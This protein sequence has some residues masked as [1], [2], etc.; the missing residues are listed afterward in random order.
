[1]KRGAFLTGEKNR[2]KTHEQLW[3]LEDGE[4]STPVHDELVLQL[5]NPRN[6]LNMCN[7]IGYNEDYW[8][9]SVTKVY[10][11]YYALDNPSSYYPR[12]Y[13]YSDDIRTEFDEFLSNSHASISQIGKQMYE[14]FCERE[15]NPIIDISC[16]YP[17][18]TGHN[19]FIIGYLDIKYN[20]T[21]LKR[22]FDIISN[23]SYEYLD[24]WYKDYEKII[25]VC[26]RGTLSV[27]NTSFNDT[28]EDVTVNIE[29]KP[30][31][32]SF[33][34]TLRQINTYRTCFSG[35]YVIYSPDVRFKAAFESQ[36]VRFI[37]PSDLGIK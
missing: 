34:E 27:I 12:N 31:I 5:M 15:R 6:A 10:P 14:N 30:K 19:K 11:N 33:G 25:K 1:L 16:E 4:L 24:Q 26:P 13:N 2:C 35:I 36:G 37:T 18:Q 22:T 23:E 32:K 29:V 21:G 20:I 9:W 17:V 8:A 28:G 7:Q 3:K